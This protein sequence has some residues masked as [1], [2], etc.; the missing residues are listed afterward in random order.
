MAVTC[1]WHLTV[2]QGDGVRRGE[3]DMGDMGPPGTHMEPWDRTGD[4]GG[5]MVPHVSSGG[6]AW[7]PMEKGTWGTRLGTWDT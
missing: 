2:V 7:K 3:E 6:R 4:T 1:M 5:R